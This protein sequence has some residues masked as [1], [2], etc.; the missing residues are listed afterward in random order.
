MPDAL[1]IPARALVRRPRRRIPPALA[2]RIDSLAWRAHLFHRFAHH[3]LCDEYAGEVIRIG[4]AR[5][6]R[7]CTFAIG[8]GLGGGVVG[9]LWRDLVAA[10]ITAS[11]AVA[12]LAAAIVVRRI[13][14]ARPPKLVT[15]FVPAA[16]LA[17]SIT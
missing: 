1:V 5:L 10:A 17:Y 14:R 13:G 11:T 16:L 2:R 7:G 4:R 8:G 3:P 15:R 6:C 9:L 12:V